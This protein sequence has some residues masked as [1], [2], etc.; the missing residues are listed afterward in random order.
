MN[1]AWLGARMSGPAGTFSEPMPRARK[2]I[3]ACRTVAILTIS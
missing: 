2:V 3:S 1:E